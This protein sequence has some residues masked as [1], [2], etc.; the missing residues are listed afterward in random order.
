MYDSSETHQEDNVAPVQIEAGMVP[1]AFGLRGSRHLR[2]WRGSRIDRRRGVGPVG[3]AHLWE[4]G[5][6]DFK[7][8]RWERRR[9]RIVPKDIA[10][11]FV[12]VQ[13]RQRFTRV[14][15]ISYFSPKIYACL[16]LSPPIWRDAPGNVMVALRAA[17]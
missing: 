6:K 13:F 11:E 8:E 17:R 10:G 2:D 3:V 14:H 15:L 5:G 16:G 7:G 4:R 9:R 12:V 1:N